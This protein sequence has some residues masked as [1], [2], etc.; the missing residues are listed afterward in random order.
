[1]DRDAELL[2]IKEAAAFLRVSETSLRRWTNSGALRCYRVGGRR[3]RRFRRSDLTAFLE[4]RDST[5]EEMPRAARSTDGQHLCALY[6]SDA[7]RI[8]QAVRFLGVHA[9]RAEACFL[10]AA[11]DVR[12]RVL[13]SLE[14]QRPSLRRDIKSGRFVLA[15]YAG[16]VARQL[17]FWDARFTAAMRAGATSLRVVGDVSGGVLAQRNPFDAVL[18]YEADYERAMSR[19]FPVTTLCQYDARLLSGV[20]V[21]RLLRCHGDSLGHPVDEL[22]G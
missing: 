22:V 20:D 16:S 3:E 7:S 2:D 1:M 13:V 14:R 10:V 5:G 19:R 9:A 6:A 12:D 15:D 11:T 4:V 21:A 18:D 8:H 17:A